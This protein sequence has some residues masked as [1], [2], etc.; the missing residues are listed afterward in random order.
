M[1]GQADEFQTKGGV[2]PPGRSLAPLSDET[3]L[4][5]FGQSDATPP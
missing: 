3:L 5:L 1:V 4:V 2:E